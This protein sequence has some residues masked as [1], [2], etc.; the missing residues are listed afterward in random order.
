MCPTCSR[1]LRAL[2]S[3][4][5][6]TLRAPVPHVPYIPSALRSSCQASSR[7][8]RVLRA[9]VPYLSCALRVLGLLVPWTLRALLLLVPDLLQ[10]FQAY[11]ALMHLMSCSFHALCSYV[12]VTLAIC[13][14]LQ[15]V[16]KLIIVT[17]SSKDTLNINDINTLYPLRI[18]T[19][20]KMSSK[21]YFLSSWL[22]TVRCFML[23]N[24][25]HIIKIDCK[26]SLWLYILIVRWGISSRL[27]EVRKHRIMKEQKKL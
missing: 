20:S 17:D 18:A 13:V 7:V 16:L 10:V 15:S 9:L 4:V 5:P 2:V 25:H 1:T 6:C 8:S 21:L 11:H 27:K 22:C 14:F 3:Y 24:V 23:S 19:Y 26:T 12:L